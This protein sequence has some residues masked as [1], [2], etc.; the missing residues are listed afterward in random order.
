MPA[1]TAVLIIDPYNDFLHPDGKLNGL[2]ATSIAETDTI[3]HLKQL[4]AAARAHKIPIYYGLHQQQRPGF[5]AGWNHA[6]SMQKSQNENK[7]FEEGTWGVKIFEGLEPSL[8]NGD[9]VVSK[10]WSSRYV[11]LL[12][13]EGMN[14]A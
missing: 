2:L 5:I 9:V 8:E 10:H 6:T 3:T 13:F 11:L 4:V 7:A 14:G 12:G 1:N